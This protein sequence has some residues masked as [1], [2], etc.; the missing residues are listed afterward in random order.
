M[1]AK[2][3]NLMFKALAELNRAEST[4]DKARLAYQSKGDIT[5]VK[6]MQESLDVAV[7]AKSILIKYS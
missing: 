2:Q 5:K 3:M 6:A 7:K 1:T 4:I